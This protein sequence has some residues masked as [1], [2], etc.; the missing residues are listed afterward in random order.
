MIGKIKMEN[1]ECCTNGGCE[2]CKDKK[3]N[4]HCFNEWCLK[5]P[6]L[7]MIVPIVLIII[8]FC[9]GAMVGGKNNFRDRGE[10]QRFMKDNFD[11]KEGFK[12]TG[13]GNITV[14]VLPNTNVEPTTPPTDVQ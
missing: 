4:F 5:Y 3:I 1:K 9:L 10:N 2:K 11:Q 14:K 7:K 6:M 8:A 13:T 12:N